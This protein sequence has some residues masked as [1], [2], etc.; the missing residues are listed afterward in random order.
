M[1]SPDDPAVVT[2]DVTY[3][4][5][6]AG[7]RQAEIRLRTTV[8]A[9]TLADAWGRLTALHDEVDPRII[10]NAP[11]CPEAAGSARPTTSGAAIT[12]TASVI[13]GDTRYTARSD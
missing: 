11:R 7:G 10:E 9:D 8:A 5:T 4:A 6:V 3:R 12:G 1:T 13:D 2:Y